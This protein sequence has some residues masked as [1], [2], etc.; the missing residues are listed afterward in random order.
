MITISQ[1]GIEATGATMGEA[2]RA[3]AKTAREAKKRNE[4]IKRNQEQAALRSQSWA[5]AFMSAPLASEGKMPKGWKLYPIGNTYGDCER[6]PEPDSE[7]RVQYE[8]KTWSKDG[9][10]IA[11][12]PF[13][14]SDTV[15]GQI[16]NSQG[17]I[18]LAVRW[19]GGSEQVLGVG[20]FGG[21]YSYHP[22]H[23]IR[24]DMFATKD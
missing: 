2:K 14:S 22:A 20:V 17:C 16:C 3:L 13:Y 7:G 24:A 19:M 9:P 21:E 12:I 1:D 11:V 23:G 4:V 8:V 5:Y 15:L 6:L 10:E 18:G